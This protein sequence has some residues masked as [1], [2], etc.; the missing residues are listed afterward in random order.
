LIPIDL[1]LPGD[2]TVSGEL[3]DDYSQCPEMLTQDILQ[4]CLPTGEVIDVG[5]WPEFD[6][7]GS[8]HI[9]VFQGDWDDQI[10]KPIEVTTPSAAAKAIRQ[11]ALRFSGSKI[12]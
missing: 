9:V 7:A 10:E 2:I 8:F 4:V 5:W 11:I 1:K 12:A 3:L 6:P